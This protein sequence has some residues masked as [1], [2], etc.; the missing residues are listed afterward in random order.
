M[1]N[2]KSIQ[3][4]DRSLGSCLFR[5]PLVTLVHPLLHDLLLHEK[6]GLLTAG[7]AG[8]LTRSSKYIV[9]DHRFSRKV[10]TFRSTIL[11][12]VRTGAQD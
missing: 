11:I 7:R 1:T 2:E 12:R 3:H 4:D 5:G 8:N 9:V 6:E 10:S